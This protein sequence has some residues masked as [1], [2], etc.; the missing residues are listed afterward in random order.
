MV[1]PEQWL[2]AADTHS[3]IHEG[4]MMHTVEQKTKA[5]VTMNEIHAKYLVNVG[6]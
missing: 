5:L 3:L 2:T 6:I 4:L 1:L